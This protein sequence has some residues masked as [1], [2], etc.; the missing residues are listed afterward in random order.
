[1]T[2]IS[3]YQLSAFP[4]EKALPKLLEKVVDSGKRA[5]ILSDTES[6]VAEINALLWTY[7]EDRFLPHGSAKD[8]FPEEQPLYITAGGENPA[9]A[10]ILVATHGAEAKDL[11]GFDRYLDMFDGNDRA[12]ITAARV[13]WKKYKEQG[14]MMTYWQQ[15]PRGG[16]DK[17]Q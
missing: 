1:M 15:N 8:R 6:S 7:Q 2:E 13:R 11:T 3:F 12:Q 17:V 5:V 14:Y 9:Q 4:L 10:T 16:W